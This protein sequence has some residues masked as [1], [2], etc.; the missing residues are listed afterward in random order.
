MTC[1]EALKKL[2]EIIDNEASRTDVD[3]VKEHLHNCKS[4]MSRYEFE[5]LFKAFVID[6]V[7]TPAKTD[8]LKAGI[9]SRCDEIDRGQAAGKNAK[10]RYWPIITVA[11]AALIICII[12]A[13]STAEFYR[14][15]KFTKPIEKIHFQSFASDNSPN[16]DISTM[17]SAGNYITND[18][19]LALSD[20]P[21]DYEMIGAGFESFQNIEFIQI[22]Y[23]H[24][25]TP[26]SLFIGH[27]DGINLPDFKKK[28][29][30]N[31][32]YFH[33]VCRGCQVIY[34][35]TGGHIA[36]AVSEDKDLDLTRLIATVDTI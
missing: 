33:H 34:W 16:P 22:K 6:K 36:I 28:K 13:F 5:K 3:Q 27:D 25:G 15:I 11:A 26:V 35:R 7:T 31:I 8:L 23:L 30:A 20:G 9:L 12:A 4:C 14:H 17:I 18:M 29:M 1:Q 10:L 21:V 2:Y 19:H 32:E 24:S